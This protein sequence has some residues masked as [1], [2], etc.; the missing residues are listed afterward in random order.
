[1]RRLLLAA[2][3]VALVALVAL[4]IP[5]PADARI[6]P[7]DDR[8]GVLSA[9]NSERQASRRRVLRFDE[10]LA[11]IAQGHAIDMARRH[12]FGHVTPEGVD[13]FG[14]MRR[15]G[16]RFRYA[17][18]NIALNANASRAHDAIW[19]EPLH[20]A[21]VLQP[22]YG[23]VGIGLVRVPDGVILVEDFSD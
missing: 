20:R 10:R 22:A 19:N 2:R 11:R 16:Y 7:A 3:L 9:L 23:R 6:R 18:E 12:Y 8:G 21:I 5:T 14:R 17:G 4:I 1:M 15:A 13:P